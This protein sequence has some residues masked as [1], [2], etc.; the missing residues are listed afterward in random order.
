MRR[1]EKIKWNLKKVGRVLC[2]LMCGS[3]KGFYKGLGRTGDAMRSLL[4]LH[5]QRGR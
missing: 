4:K 3:T 1:V 5:G 2:G